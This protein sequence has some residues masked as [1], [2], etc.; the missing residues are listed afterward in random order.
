MYRSCLFCG[1]SLGRN[2]SLERF[3]LGRRLAFDH[4][5]GRLWV[6]C[7][8]CDQWNLAP[9]EERWEVVEEC[10]R[11]FADTTLRF[12]TDNIGLARLSGGA[13]L[14]RVGKPLRPEFAAW[15]YGDQFGW[16]RRRV[17]GLATA[18]TG[19]AASVL[20]GGVAAATTAGAA[21]VGWKL[22]TAV[23]DAQR[24]HRRRKQL[25]VDT[26]TVMV[27][28]KELADVRVLLGGSWG[29]SWGLYVPHSG[30]TS[31]L[32]GTDAVRSAGVLL[33][34]INRF[35][36]YASQVELAVDILQRHR[37]AMTCFRWAAAQ[38]ERVRYRLARLPTAIRLALEMAAHEETERRALEGRLA[39][40]RR[41]WQRAEQVASIADEL[42]APA[43]P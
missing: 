34:R 23:G 5:R 31:I 42:L 36:A 2:R 28:R 39:V 35:G 38:P 12:A 18:A 7:R 43:L 6:V 1:S 16:R 4:A 11:R 14:I 25:P 37:D 26:D 22:G 24:R 30:G 8:S 19:T 27:G 29:D 33:A 41:R 13:E 15:R 32:S 10:E 9:I 20:I 17:L 21:L 3:T 40:Y